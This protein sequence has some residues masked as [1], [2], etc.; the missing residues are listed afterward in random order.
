MAIWEASLLLVDDLWDRQLVH[1][2]PNGFVAA[3]PNRNILAFCDAKTPDGPLQ[4]RRIIQSG[5]G[6]HPISTTLYCRD[7]TLREWRLLR[8]RPRSQTERAALELPQVPPTDPLIYRFCELVQVYGTIWKELI[9]EEFGDGIMSA[10]DFDMTM[11]CQ[12]DQ[13]GD[14][15]KIGMSGKFLGYKR[16]NRLTEHNL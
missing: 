9:Q 5:A 4:L 10:V 11:E 2:A 15:V 12:P 6:D 8:I 16:I 7:P 3:V 13:K 1:L 14:R